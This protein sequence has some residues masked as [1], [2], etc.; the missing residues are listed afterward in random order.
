MNIDKDIVLV[1]DYHSKNLSIRWFDSATGEER[2]LSRPT[3]VQAIQEVVAEARSV[4][5]ARGGRVVWIMESTTGWSRVKDLIGNQV[6]FLLANVL[7]I[8]LPPKAHRR[9]TDKLDTKRLLREYLNGDLPLATQPNAW[10]RRLRRLVGIREDLV[11]RRTAVRNWI[12][13]YFAHESWADGDNLWSGRGMKRLKKF[14]AA[15]EDTDRFVLDKKIRELEALAVEVLEVEEQLQAIYD[16]CPAAQRLSVIKG[17]NVVSSVSIVA[18]I[19]PIERFVEPE[20]LIAYAGLA[21]GVRQSDATSRNLS[22]GGGG[23]DVQLRH[24]LIEASLWARDI[25]RY[26]PTYERA[27]QR[28]GKKVGR[29]VVARLLLRSIHKMLRDEVAFTP[30]MA[31]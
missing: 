27:M 28:R 6:V 20:Q 5:M 11:S 23:T 9:K 21:P 2:T 19:G 14:A 7:Q 17:I 3:E 26:R 29:I 13:C 10:W 4:A 25:P 31:A 22:I 12:R 8:P 15:A 30:S 1:V 18:R 24:Y 16:S